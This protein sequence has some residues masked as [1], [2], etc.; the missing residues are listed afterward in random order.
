MWNWLVG[1]LHKLDRWLHR[2]KLLAVVKRDADSFF[3]PVPETALEKIIFVP[4]GSSFV[5]YWFGP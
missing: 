3:F 4:V 5:T 2:N 1:L